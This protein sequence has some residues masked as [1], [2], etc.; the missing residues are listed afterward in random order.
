MTKANP[1][2]GL[3]LTEHVGL[4]QRLF[5]TNEQS[6]QRDN[7]GTA[8]RNNGTTLTADN[9]TT[10]LAVNGQARPRVNQGAGE[11]RNG[12]PNKRPIGRSGVANRLTAPIE[13]LV[14]RHSHDIYHDQVLW[15]NRVKFELEEQYGRRV[16]SNSIVQLAIDRLRRD[17]EAEAHPFEITTR[18]IEGLLPLKSGATEQKGGEDGEG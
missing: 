14:E 16:T 6:N 12:A 2:S 10:S 15:I 4:D 13:R 8:Q 5:S 1:F 18:L 11:R 7:E 3:K 17:F 9:E